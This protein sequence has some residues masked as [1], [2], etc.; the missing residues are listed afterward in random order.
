M[1]W[2][3]IF[4]AWGDDADDAWES[5]I[6]EMTTENIYYADPHMGGLKGRDAMIGMVAKFRQMMAGGYARA[7]NDDGYNGH[8][9][10][11]VTFGKGG[12]DMMTGQYFAQTDE[13]GKI[14]RLVGFSSMP[15]A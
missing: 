3:E 13:A 4:N 6:A 1:A 7:K 9:R 10:A 12:A 2:T 11:A 8:G 15:K 14:T 5:R